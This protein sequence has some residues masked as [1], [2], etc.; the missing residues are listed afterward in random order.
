L[1]GVVG[2]HEVFALG[3]LDSTDVKSVEVSCPPGERALGGG[4]NI[5]KVEPN[6]PVAVQLSLA[7]NDASG[8]SIGWQVTA[9]EVTAYAN[10]WRPVVSVI[11][12]PG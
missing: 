9:V 7:V 8:K 2:A 10:I 6:P 12:A 3:T 11:C 5:G 4:F 1:S